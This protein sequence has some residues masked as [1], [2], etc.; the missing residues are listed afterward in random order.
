MEEVLNHEPDSGTEISFSPT[1]SHGQKGIVITY[2]GRDASEGR[3]CFGVLM[4]DGDWAK[5]LKSAVRFRKSM[6]EN[7]ELE[8]VENET[9]FGVGLLRQ[10]A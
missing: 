1:D 7:I 8:L 2:R 6:L 9:T 3:V 10:G 5:D 4:G